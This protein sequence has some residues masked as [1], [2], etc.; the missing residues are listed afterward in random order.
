GVARLLGAGSG[1]VLAASLALVP[2]QAATPPAPDA[3]AAEDLSWGADQNTAADP[4]APVQQSSPATP[5]QSSRP[6]RQDSSRAE[7]PQH[8]RAEEQEEA[9]APPEA[10]VASQT[11]TPPEAGDQ[12]KD[13]APSPRTRPP[14][15]ATASTA[16][17]GYDEQPRDPTCKLAVFSQT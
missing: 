11:G 15:A 6:E 3:P 4:P 7:P 14:H 5:Q 16:H 1:A 13:N 10:G 2:A 8:S 9:A 17:T 12:V